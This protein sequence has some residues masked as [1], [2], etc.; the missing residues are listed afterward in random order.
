MFSHFDQSSYIHGISRIHGLLVVVCAFSVF[1]GPPSTL[2]S[3]GFQ[4]FVLQFFPRTV[5]DA[6]W[7]QPMSPPTLKIV[8]ENRPPMG[9]RFLAA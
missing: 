3:S 2:L 6:Q 4:L 5:D 7:G 1:T 9:G 8:D